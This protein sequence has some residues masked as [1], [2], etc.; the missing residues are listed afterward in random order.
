MC[1][2]PS[3][4]DIVLCRN[5]PGLSGLDL[6]SE[7]ARREIQTPI[8]F[9]TGHG[10]IPMSVRAMK[11]GAVDF[12]TKPFQHRDLLGVI[13]N[14]LSKDVRLVSARQI[15]EAVGRRLESLTQR[16]REVFGL[17]I[18]GLLNKQ[19]AAELG[20][21]E[22]TIKV[23]RRRIMEKMGVVSVAELVQAAV[24]AGVVEAQGG[25]GG[26]SSGGEYGTKVVRT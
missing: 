1:V 14:A 5:L 16:E 7:L 24:K 8:V 6:Q 22:Q 10:D 25:T 11:A 20:A 9:I 19:I 4:G 15:R 17:V 18:K 3:V 13:R 23:H 12:L 2:W 26:P 21:K